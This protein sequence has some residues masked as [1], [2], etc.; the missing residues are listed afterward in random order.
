MTDGII[1]S[2]QRTIEGHKFIQT[3]ASLNPGSSGGPLFDD[4]G[5]VIG[6]IAAKANIE[7]TGFAVP[8]SEIIDF[9]V[10]SAEKSDKEIGLQRQ[11]HD[12]SNRFSVGAKLIAVTSDKVKLLT[13]DGRE[14]EIERSRL[15]KPDRE[16]LKLFAR[17][18]ENAVEVSPHAA[19]RLRSGESSLGSDRRRGFGC[20]RRA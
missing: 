14:L 15:C 19:R 13:D 12:D 9:L 20:Q 11:W 2:P 1:S 6:M 3:S 4:H 7:A 8:A 18:N 17:T 10:R 5:V 16:L